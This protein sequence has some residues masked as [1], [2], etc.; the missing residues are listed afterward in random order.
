VFHEPT[1]DVLSRQLNQV[2]RMYT[3]VALDE[4]V[5]RLAKAKSTVGIAAITFDD[6]VGAVTEAGAALAA[7]H[8]WPMTFY[9]PTRYLDTRLPYWFLE[10]D[11]L[12]K[13][14]AGQT[15]QLGS[16][17]FSLGDPSSIA[18]TSQ[19]LRARFKT[20]ATE[21]EVE[22]LLRRIRRS[23]FADDERPLGLSFP[24]PIGWDRVRQLAKRS[25]VSFEAHTINHLAVSR[26]TEEKLISEMQGS[27]SRIEEITGRPVNH[28]CY[29]YGSPNE[30]GPAAPKKVREL[31]RSGTTTS[32]GR[33][34]AGVD[35]ALL[36]RVPLDEL[37]SEEVV[38]LKVSTA[39]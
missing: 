1:P 26:I 8:G 30:I 13:R 6:G 39:R 2:A 29:P 11:L 34:S 18:A 15:L 9:L 14:G 23:L 38:E 12:L 35:L 7:V 24:E 20:L 37:D 31:F 3:F 5:D 16:E 33:C 19:L 32:R 22:H 17:R 25:E 21:E 28:F 4:F 36:P 10:L 27:R